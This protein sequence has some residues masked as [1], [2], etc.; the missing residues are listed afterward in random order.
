[1]R[2]TRAEATQSGMES[3]F[4][5]TFLY[6]VSSVAMSVVLIGIVSRCQA[7]LEAGLMI[8]KEHFSV[9]QRANT[10]QCVT[11]GALDFIGY[12]LSLGDPVFCGISRLMSR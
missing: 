6:L 8:G 12:V 3:K 1:M 7:I 5:S 2:Y 9:T 10:T 11:C 4:F